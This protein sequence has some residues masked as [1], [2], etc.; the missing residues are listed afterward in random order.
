MFAQ[1][2]LLT[3]KELIDILGLENVLSRNEFHTVNIFRIRVEEPSGIGKRRLQL[4]TAPIESQRAL[5]VTETCPHENRTR[6]AAERAIGL[7]TV[8]HQAGLKTFRVFEG[9]STA[10]AW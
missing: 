9:Q 1:P 6:T 4:G 8:A 10:G 7:L 3:N 5:S 2:D